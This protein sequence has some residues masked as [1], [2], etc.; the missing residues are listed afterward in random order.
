MWRPPLSPRRVRIVRVARESR[1]RLRHVVPG[2]YLLAMS[3]SVVVYT[4]KRVAI[5]SVRARRSILECRLACC[6]AFWTL[7][8]DFS[9]PAEHDVETE[10]FHVLW[11]GAAAMILGQG[12]R[13]RR[14]N[15]TVHAL[16]PPS[17]PSFASGRRRTQGAAL[18]A[19]EIGVLSLRGEQGS[20]SHE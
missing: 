8:H 7:G 6:D 17:R 1:G 16:L 3:R 9:L 19:G 2:R 11:K 12:L 15:R 20:G 13:G 14:L 10:S 4:R 5:V 18:S